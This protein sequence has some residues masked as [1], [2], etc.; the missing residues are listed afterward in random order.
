MGPGFDPR[1]AHQKTLQKQ[2][3]RGFPRK[4]LR[5][6]HARILVQ[7]WSKRSPANVSVVLPSVPHAP[8]RDPW[9]R[10]GAAGS[11][12]HAW[13][14]RF[15]ASSLDQANRRLVQHPRHRWRLAD[16]PAARRRR[17]CPPPRADVHLD[18][19]GPLTAAARA[20]RAVVT[21]AAY[22]TTVTRKFSSALCLWRACVWSGAGVDSRLSEKP[23]F[24]GENL[25]PRTVRSRS[26]SRAS[27]LA[28]SRSTLDAVARSCSCVATRE[29]RNE[30]PRYSPSRA[31]R[32]TRS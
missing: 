3:V 22:R 29:P 24:A 26:S 8:R 18:S 11:W 15:R 23:L 10:G 25:R 31:S 20:F 19:P 21:N 6:Q 7:P 17:V 14:Q 5:S 16:F 28:C 1:R 4:R 9:I 30:A 27:P 12:K 13:I 32:V 2:A